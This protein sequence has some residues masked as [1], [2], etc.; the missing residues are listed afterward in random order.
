MTMMLSPSLYK[1]FLVC[2]SKAFF[3]LDKSITASNR[4]NPAAALGRVAH[5]L[6]EE[7]SR[8]PRD[9]EEDT[10]KDWFEAKWDEYTHVIFSE[11]QIEWAPNQVLAP[12][13]WRGY[14]KAKMAAK[15]LVIK[16]SGLLP[17]RLSLN[18]S[19]AGLTESSSPLLHLPLIEKR[20][21]DTSLRIQGTPDY[22][23]DDLGKLIIFDYKFG[24]DQMD[25]E[26]HRMQMHFY[27][28][29][30]EST[31]RR[32]VDRCA[33]VASANQIYE[34][35]IDRQYLEILKKEIPNA[36]I[37]LESGKIKAKP[38]LNNCLFCPYKMDCVDFTH[39]NILT[40]TG[41]PLVISGE[42]LSSKRISEDF[43]EISVA[44]KSGRVNSIYKIFNVPLNYR[45]DNAL[46]VS[47]SN[48]LFFHK[49]FLVEFQWNSQLRITSSG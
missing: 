20:L 7:S 37:L 17:R 29:L 2:Q 30:V 44:S 38:S 18:S 14:F 13:T 26:D 23:F 43:Q 15:T 4:T 10:L 5:K 40:N 36:I 19:L 16:N 32:I 42:F 1:R 48:H 39:S 9:W 3:S 12:E 11:M 27:V 47:F 45:F 34:I 41:H 8:N 28:L 33:I 6:V 49:E 35:P 22:V 31:L 46:N 21:Q 24:H 25:L